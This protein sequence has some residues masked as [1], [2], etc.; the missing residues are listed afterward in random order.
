MKSALTIATALVATTSLAQVTF[1]NS[2]STIL[3]TDNGTYGDPIE[4]VHYY[5]DQLPIG[6]SVASDGRIWTCYTRG[7]YEYTLGIIVNKTAEAPWPMS[8]PIQNLPPSMINTTFNGIPFGSANKS[9]LISVQ[10]LY[11]T[12]QTANRPE[13][14]WAIDTGR[15]TIHNAQGDPMEVYGQPGGPKLI[16]FNITGQNDTA[17][18]TFTFPSDV[19]YPDSYFNDLRFDLRPD[20]PGTS[21]KGIAYL[22]DSSDEGRPGF[23]MLDLGTGESWR[24][25]SEDPSVLRVNWNVPS[26]QGRPFYYEPKGMPINTLREGLDGIQ[27]SPDGSRI[28]YSPLTSTYL[29]SIPTTNLRARNSDPLAELAAHSNISSHGQRGADANGFEGDNQGRVYML[30]PTEN[31]VFYY[32][33][34]DLQTHGFVRDPRI[35]WPD[36]ASVAEDGYFYMTATQLFDQ[37][38]WNNGTDGRMKPGAI[39]RAKLPDGAGKIHLG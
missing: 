27:I 33:P 5:Y 21:G 6:L 15:P 36:S 38:D 24:R 11:I 3:R 30:M 31:G 12:P 7:S 20:T 19:Y 8:G 22:V 16:G 2:S 39:L 35:L 32:D 9:G 25:L 17:Y 14:L 28:Y 4:E 10:A 1:E 26:Y 34:G 23:I 37:P 18:E 13:T 29:Y